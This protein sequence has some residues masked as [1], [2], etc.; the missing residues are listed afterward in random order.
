MAVA[1]LDVLHGDRAQLVGQLDRRVR[2]QPEE[3]AG[4]STGTADAQ[5]D[6]DTAA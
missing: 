1:A 3:D 4:P 5:R 6:P 2:A